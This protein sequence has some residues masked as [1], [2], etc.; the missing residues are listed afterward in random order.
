MGW[1]GYIDERLSLG[2]LEGVGVAEKE[3]EFSA[4]T[5]AS[6][7]DGKRCRGAKSGEEFG[8][9][10]LSDGDTVE[11]QEGEKIVSDVDSRESSEGIQRLVKWLSQRFQERNLTFLRRPI[12][13]CALLYPYSG[14]DRVWDNNLLDMSLPSFLLRWL[15]LVYRS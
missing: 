9:A 10:S 3:G 8:Y 6:A 5:E 7:T 4:P 2:G 11:E 12:V 14:G 1:I 15:K 13:S